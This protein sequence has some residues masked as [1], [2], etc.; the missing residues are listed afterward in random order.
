MQ[1]CNYFSLLS[2]QIIFHRNYTLKIF[3]LK[4]KFSEKNKMFN[5]P[6]FHLVL[7]I[8]F[9]PIIFCATRSKNLLALSEENW[10]DILTGEWMIELYFLIFFSLILFILRLISSLNFILATLHGVLPAKIFKRHG[11]PLPIGQRI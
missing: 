11:I 1:T 4:R 2:S 3:N 7:I 10:R 9:L 5:K 8:S 6:L